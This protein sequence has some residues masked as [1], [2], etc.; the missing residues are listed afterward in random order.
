[1]AL[2]TL[3]TEVW[4]IQ[5]VYDRFPVL[6]EQPH[7]Q[8]HAPVLDEDN[9]AGIAYARSKTLDIRGIVTWMQNESRDWMDFA[10]LPVFCSQYFPPPPPRDRY[11]ADPFYVRLNCHCVHLLDH[12]VLWYVQYISPLTTGRSHGDRWHLHLIHQSG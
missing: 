2:V 11:H 6:R 12:S 10:R 7:T 8:T 4:W 5:I 3:A 1:M 9:D